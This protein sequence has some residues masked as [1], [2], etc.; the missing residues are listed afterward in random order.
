MHFLGT[1][2]CISVGIFA[3]VFSFIVAH[4]LFGW[5]GVA[6]NILLFP[7]SS[8]VA[9]FY[10]WIIAG[11]WVPAAILYVGL[12]VGTTLQSLGKKKA[13]EKTMDKLVDEF[14]NKK[15]LS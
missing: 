1:M 4:E 7:L 11:N 5:I 9:P 13:F 6:V 3:V 2:I 15:E 12:G 10:R 14:E 8:W